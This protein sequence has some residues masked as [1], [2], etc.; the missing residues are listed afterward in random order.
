M[1]P[2]SPPQSRS[3]T[4]APPDTTLSFTSRQ[5]SHPDNLSFP[6]LFV[7][8]IHVTTSGYAWD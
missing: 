7:L 6:S 4:Q 1:C 8:K 2:E 3:R 5:D